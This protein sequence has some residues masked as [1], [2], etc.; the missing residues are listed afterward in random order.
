MDQDR[1]DYCR[2]NGLCPECLYAD[3][4]TERD[5]MYEWEQCVSCGHQWDWKHVAG[6]A[7]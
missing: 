2:D 5:E 1:L 7:S 3:T 6:E 4:T